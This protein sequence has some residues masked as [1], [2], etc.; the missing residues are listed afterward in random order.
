[1]GR[2]TQVHAPVSGLQLDPPDWFPERAGDRA[3]DR[4]ETNSKQEGAARARASIT[5]I[6]RRRQTRAVGADPIPLA[7]GLV[8]RQ[9][10]GEGATAETADAALGERHYSMI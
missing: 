6:G 10:D 5:A 8:G 1:M 7:L 4:V 9:D 3:V 2:I